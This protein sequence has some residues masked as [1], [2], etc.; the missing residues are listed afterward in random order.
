MYVSARSSVLILIGRNPNEVSF[1]TVMLTDLG[2]SRYYQVKHYTNWEGV[3]TEKTVYEAKVLIC[4]KLKDSTGPEYDSGEVK[5]ELTH[6]KMGDIAKLIKEYKHNVFKKY[7]K[8]LTVWMRQGKED[9]VDNR[10]LWDKLTTAPLV[11]PPC[12]LKLI[13]LSE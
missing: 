1:K 8:A 4:A 2:I 13:I 5:V 6:K 9:D 12:I 7:D 11:C 3:K 10:G